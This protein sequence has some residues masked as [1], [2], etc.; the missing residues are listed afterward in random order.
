MDRSPGNSIFWKAELLWTMPRWQPLFYDFE[1]LN[2][3]HKCILNA[4]L[5]L[6]FPYPE[7]C[8]ID[9]GLLLMHVLSL[10]SVKSI[11]YRLFSIL[12]S[13]FIHNNFCFY[14]VW[15]YPR[16]HSAMRIIWAACYGKFYFDFPN[17]SSCIRCS[18]SWRPWRGGSMSCLGSRPSWGNGKQRWKHPGADAHKTGVSM[19]TYSVCF[20]AQASCTRDTIFPDVLHSGVGKPRTLGAAAENAI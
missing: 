4:N 11:I 12:N 14:N 7:P 13:D 2:K 10:S 6:V 20:S 8:H 15:I 1:L 9:D 19:F 5:V 16:S 3:S 17:R 18:W